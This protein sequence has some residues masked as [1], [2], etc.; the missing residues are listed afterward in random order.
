MDEVGRDTTL[1]K[2]ARVHRLRRYA[3]IATILA[4]GG[5]SAA[6]SPTVRASA[7]SNFGAS[8]SRVWWFWTSNVPFSYT[9]YAGGNGTYTR[10]SLDG[11]YYDYVSYDSDNLTVKAGRTVLPPNPIYVGTYLQYYQ[12]GYNFVN[13][14]GGQFYVNCLK[15]PTDSAVCVGDHPDYDYFE[16]MHVMQV[17]EGFP[18]SGC[19]TDQNE[20]WL[21]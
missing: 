15:S 16:V 21:K 18:D 13:R 11:D 2:R 20:L 3:T 12:E 1:R 19:C 14:W 5:I 7:A 4:V 10:A 6:I 8:T 17:Y 9:V